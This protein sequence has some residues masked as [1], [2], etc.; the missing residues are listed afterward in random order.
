MISPIS[1]STAFHSLRRCLENFQGTPCHCSPILV[2]CIQQPP[3]LLRVR[4]GVAVRCCRRR[5]AGSRRLGS[6]PGWPSVHQSYDRSMQC[7]YLLAYL[8]NATQPRC[9]YRSLASVDILVVLVPTYLL[10]AHSERA[11]RTQRAATISIR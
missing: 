1:V 7:V 4:F 8:A 5:S 9:C 3:R 6:H 2:L 10:L 11:Y